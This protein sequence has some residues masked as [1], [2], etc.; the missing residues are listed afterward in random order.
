MA[1]CMSAPRS[2]PPADVGGGA[3]GA[4]LLPLGRPA[5]VVVAFALVVGAASGCMPAEGGPAGGTGGDPGGGGGGSGGVTGNPDASA[6]G[7]GGT[8]AG[9]GGAGVAGASGT[10]G[11]GGSGA[12]TGGRGGGASGGAGGRG[13]AGTGGR[14]GAGTGGR[15]GTGGSGAGGRGGAGA[16]GAGTGGRAGTGGAGGVSSSRFPLRISA[17]GRLIVDQ[18]GTPFLFQG[19]AAWG[20][21]AAA[22]DD[23]VER[24]LENRRQKGFNAAIVR[25][26]EHHFA[27]NPPLNVAGQGPFTTPGDFSTP[28]EAYFAHADWVIQ[29][30]LDKGILV[31]LCPAYLGW[32]G[33]HEGWYMEM[34][35]SGTAKLREFG[36]YLGNRYKRFPNIM[37]VNAG[38]YNPPSPDVVRAVALGILENDTVHLHTAHCG[39]T[40]S[41]MDCFPNET[42]LNVNASYTN[43]V[44][45]DQVLRDYARTPFKPFFLL[46]PQY[47]NE[48]ESTRTTLRSQAYWA[49][50]S[51]AQ[52][53]DFGNN[54][55]WAFSG[56]PLYPPPHGWDVGLDDPGA[57]D[58]TRVSA[59]FL[60][61]PWH[62][63]VPDRTHT[64]L[65][66]GY[67]TYTTNAAAIDNNYVAAARTADGRLVMAY[68]PSTGTAARSVT[69]DMTKL[70][71]A[72]NGRWY[73]PVSGAYTAITGSPFANTGTRS[74]T[75]PGNNGSGAGDWALVLEVP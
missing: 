69:I 6:T 57:G 43:F 30:A 74:F 54:P 39:R 45:Y 41:A 38:D 36:R 34:V 60:G 14:G 61:R 72:A 11:R 42:W 23:Q 55:V 8:A 20:L 51:G 7:T 29:R 37:W 52:G 1:R 28:N 27:D 13:G 70:A 10:G 53:Q 5:L 9:T 32:G 56:P 15:A 59:L 75:T 64:T 66:A 22:T 67:G 62:T 2:Q 58:M 65:T 25:L 71:G 68:I 4:W 16:G 50:L 35:A 47:E 26:M 19:D 63:L 21:I 49:I 40:N 44:T 17:D 18:S 46:D 48:N 33:M 24:Y 3:R 12:S 73:N 31:L